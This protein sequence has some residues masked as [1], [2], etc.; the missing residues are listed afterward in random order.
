MRRKKREHLSGTADSTRPD[1]AAETVPTK[2]YGN[3]FDYMR[4]TRADADTRSASVSKELETAFDRRIEQ[5]EVPVIVFS[6]IGAAEMAK[7]I[8]SHPIVLKPLLAI[9][10]LAGRALDRDLGIKNVDTYMPDLTSEQAALIAGYLIHFLPACVE[11]PALVAVDRCEYIDK[12]VRKLKGQWEK[13]IVDSLCKYGKKS[14]CK[15]KFK[16][17]SES[18]ELDAACPPTGTISIGVDIKR[19]EAKRDIHKRCDEIV[20][21]AAKFKRAFPKGMFGAIIYYPFTTE[22]I[23]VEHRLRSTDIDAVAFAGQTPDSV[24]LAVRMLLKRLQTGGT[25]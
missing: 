7:A 11:V 22:H 16:A 20:S 24:E 12:E 21:K 4:W 15:R 18:Y 8:E 25:H 17:D 10:N 3:H 14:F 9:C 1:E 19:V 5:R 23:N 13:D 6:G 2:D